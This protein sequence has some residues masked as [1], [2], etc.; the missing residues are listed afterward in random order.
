MRAFCLMIIIAVS[1]SQ[2][3]V[4]CVVVMDATLRTAS[5]FLCDNLTLSLTGL[6]DIYL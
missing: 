5:D 1:Y 2:D 6:T 3:D 4:L